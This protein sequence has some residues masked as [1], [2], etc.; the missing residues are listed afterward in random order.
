MSIPLCPYLSL[1]MLDKVYLLRKT[2][3]SIACVGILTNDK[4]Y[5]MCM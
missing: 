4:L 2:G 3:Y 5:V 1:A